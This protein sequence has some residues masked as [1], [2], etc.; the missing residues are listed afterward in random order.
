MDNGDILGTP[1]ETKHFDKNIG[2]MI[3][4]IHED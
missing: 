2:I 4:I 3:D 1:K